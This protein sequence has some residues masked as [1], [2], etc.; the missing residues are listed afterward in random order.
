[1]GDLSV[2]DSFVC[3]S[4]DAF[5]TWE[6]SAFLSGDAFAPRLVDGA[7]EVVLIVI[8]PSIGIESGVILESS[9]GFVGDEV[10][11]GSDVSRL[12]VVCG[13]GGVGEGRIAYWR[14]GVGGLVDGGV[15]LVDL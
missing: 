9:D 3:F 5:I 1:M 11:A 2:Q 12:R 4:G 15:D 14:R 10:V 7:K 8:G 13:L 6:C